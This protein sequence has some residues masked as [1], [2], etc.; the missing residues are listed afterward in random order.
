MSAGI[1]EVVALSDRHVTKA[2]YSGFSETVH[3]SQ[4][5]GGHQLTL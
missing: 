5:H 3:I 4:M 1:V 2:K